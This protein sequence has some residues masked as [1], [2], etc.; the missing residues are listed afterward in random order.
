MPQHGT[1]VVGQVA[2]GDDYYQVYIAVSVR[3]A[4]SM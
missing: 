1:L 4:P 3:Y 2:M